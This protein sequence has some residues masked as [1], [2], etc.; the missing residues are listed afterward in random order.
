M[1]VPMGGQYITELSQEH[2]RH[3][4]GV[5]GTSMLKML[6]I[7]SLAFLTEAKPESIIVNGSYLLTVKKNK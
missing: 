2:G 5:R 4:Y 3:F 7:F 1:N 6:C